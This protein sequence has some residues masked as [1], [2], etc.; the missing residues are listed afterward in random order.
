[1]TPIDMLVWK[2]DIE[3]SHRQ[4]K[5]CKHVML[6]AGELV[7]P[8][9][10]PSLVTQYQMFSPEIPHRQVTLNGVRR[11]YLYIIIHIHMHTH[12][13]NKNKEKRSSF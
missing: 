2:G 3:G 8:G 13:H 9:M 1:M 11:L 6:I 10:S 4:S 7:S 12:M 5:D